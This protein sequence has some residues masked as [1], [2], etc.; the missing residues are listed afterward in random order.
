MNP[1]PAMRL[2]AAE[3]AFTLPEVQAA[4]AEWLAANPEREPGSRALMQYGF[5]REQ[6]RKWFTELVD[7][8]KA[9]REAMDAAGITTQ[10]LL[11]SAPGVQIF[12]EPQG[13]SLAALV[14]DRMAEV[15]QHEP[16]RYAPLAAIAPRHHPRVAVIAAT[17][18]PP[19]TTPVSRPL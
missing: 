17:S 14:N 15:A 6:A 3:E 5:G 19:S 13:T 10:L 7:F 18:P 2:V 11:L 1:A 8:G 16:A 9:R 4:T 12:D